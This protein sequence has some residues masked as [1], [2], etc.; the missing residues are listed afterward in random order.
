MSKIPRTAR[1]LQ[2]QARF[3]EAANG[4]FGANGFAGSTITQ[5]VEASG[6]SVGSFY[7]QF[8][9]KTQLLQRGMQR[10][11]EDFRATLA[12]L[13]LQR[14]GNGDVFTLLY[15]LTRAGRELVQRNRGIYRATSEVAQNDISSFGPLAS[16]GPGVAVRV[17]AVLPQYQDQ[18]RAPPN[19]ATVAHAVQLITMSTLQ[20]ELGMGPMFPDDHDGFARVI[21]RAACGVLAYDGQTDEPQWPDGQ[22]SA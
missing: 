3:L 19:R 22:A 7:H 17:F 15:R 12:G 6:L 16:I 4:V 13:I 9:D 5:I 14:S 18:L 8:D 20:A 1:G 21:A 10:V 2:A 11:A